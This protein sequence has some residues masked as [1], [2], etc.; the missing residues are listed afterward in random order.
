VELENFGATLITLVVWDLTDLVCEDVAPAHH[1]RQSSQSP[2]VDQLQK[3]LTMDLFR[4][5][6][7]LLPKPDHH[8]EAH[9]RPPE[10]P[11]L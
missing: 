8:P 6:K 10:A 9:Q 1:V 3:E 11:Q 5:P 4:Q 2:L 7:G